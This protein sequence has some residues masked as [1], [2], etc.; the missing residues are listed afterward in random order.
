VKHTW[1]IAPLALGSAVRD[2]SQTL[3]GKD[4]GIKLEGAILAWLL[5]S[6]E[7]KILVDTGAFGRTYRPDLSSRY[8]QTPH[9]TMESQLRRFNVTAQEIGLV[10]N[11]HLHLDHAGGNGYF[12]QARFMVQK[13]ELEYAKDPLPV[14]KGGYDVDLSGLPF[15]LLEGDAE[16]VPGVR[17]VLT[18]GHSPGS[19]AVLVDT[20]EGL[21]VI[22]GDT[23]TH[24]VNMDVPVGDSFWPNAIYVDLAEYYRSLDR[25]RDLGGVILPGHDPR[26]LRNATY[27]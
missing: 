11:T 12:P 10:I 14:H 3:L 4:Y 9:Q 6:G 26:V 19:Q 20:E 16:I 5:L 2:R 13:K 18:P 21:Y 8:D 27:P 15:E 25:L 22:A 1:T 23:I 24:H 7:K 17:V